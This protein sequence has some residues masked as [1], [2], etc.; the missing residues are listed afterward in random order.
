MP[1]PVTA[2]TSRFREV[3][4]LII[5]LTKLYLSVGEERAKTLSFGQ[6]LSSNSWD[7]SPLLFLILNNFEC[8]RFYEC[9]ILLGPQEVFIFFQLNLDQQ[10]G[11]LICH[12]NQPNLEKQIT[13]KLPAPLALT[14][15]RVQGGPLIK[16]KTIF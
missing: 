12:F 6:I 5:P 13:L 11:N 2:T 3:L 9:W 10:K 16:T 8:S 15:K 1:S 14:G 7:T 4:L